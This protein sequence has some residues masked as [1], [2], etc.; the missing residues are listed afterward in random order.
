MAQ[1]ARMAMSTDFL[2]AF[3]KLPSAQQKGVRM[4]IAK[5]E[6]NPRSPGLNYESIKAARD[7]NMR[8]LRVDQDYRAIVL[9]PN[10]GDTHLLLWADK[11]DK[12]YAWA[13]RHECGVNPETGAIQIYSPAPGVREP[14]ANQAIAAASLPGGPFASLKPRQLMRL[15]VPA[16]MAEEVRAA[17]GEE[18]FDALK[19]RLPLEAHDSLFY[20]LAGDSY[21]KV[22]RDREISDDEVDTTDF[23][24]ALLR[25]ETRS[26]FVLV[27]DE[28]E[29]EAMLNAPLERWRVFLHPSQRRLVERDWNG[30]IRLL[31]AAGTGKTV[32]AMHRARWLARKSPGSKKVLFITFNRNL[33]IDIRNNLRQICSAD[34]FKRIEVKNLDAWVYGF[35]KRSSYE[36]QIVYGRDKDAWDQA[37]HFQPSGIDLP[38]GFFEAEWEHVVQANGVTSEE[39]YKRVSRVGRGVRLSRAGRAEVWKVFEEY[40]LQLAG[41]GLKEIED[42]YRDAVALIKAGKSDQ[43]YSA[44]IVDEAQ[45]L[46]SQAF[47]LIRSLVPNAVND[48]FITGD[49]HQ[50][51][52][53]R[54]VV[55]GQCGIDIRGRSRKLRLNYR[56]T[57]QTRAWAARLLAGRSIDD[58]DGGSDNNSGIR[59]LTKG[60]E[61]LLRNFDT[62]EQQ[63]EAIVQYLK[64]L[65]EPECRLADTCIVVRT[66]VERAAIEE[67]LRAEGLDVVQIDRDSDDRQEEGVR[68]ATMHR[69]KGLEFER[70]VLAS[71]N[72]NLVPLKRSVDAA[73]DNTNRTAAETMERA[74]VYV[75]AS[76]AK[77]ELLVLSYGSPSPLLGG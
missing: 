43:K 44:V 75:A 15:G 70:I 17:R 39:D 16:A 60:P 26:R 71:M 67:S 53:G 48:L 11:H 58:L 41:R 66:N 5:F 31:G 28:V 74:L 37:R 46:G 34:E 47:R 22:V 51:I 42:A 65:P 8:S 55:L 6:A 54:K 56:T 62:R 72:A 49:G 14:Q 61:P 64:N 69:V 9:R 19:D 76:R 18:A 32:V 30:P 20:Y 29:L 1:N 2:E 50:R 36:F 7:S 57:E 52:Y 27:H 73:G 23:G 77:K 45:D 12:A 68:L 3:A 24:K 4:L 35:L 10:K 21:E 38:K 25:D 13:S 59:S 33:A 63:V 40:M